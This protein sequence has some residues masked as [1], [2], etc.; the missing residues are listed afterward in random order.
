MTYTLEQLKVLSEAAT[1][2]PWKAD[3]EYSGWKHIQFLIREEVNNGDGL[4][5]HNDADTAFIAAARTAVPELI[6][7]VNRCHSG[8]HYKDLL[9]E[10]SLL[11]EKIAQQPTNTL[12][13][14]SFREAIRSEMLIL[15]IKEN[16]S[17]RKKIDDAP[18]DKDCEYINSTSLDPSTC[19]CWKS[20]D[21]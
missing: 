20:K 11:K 6:N 1:K 2:G 12:T 7:E 5:L 10:I 17:L 15:T 18:H 9:A 3:Y 21:V 4:N 14:I 19:N 8:Q 13:D 16:R